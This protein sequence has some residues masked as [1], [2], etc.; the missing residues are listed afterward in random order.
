MLH[1]IDEKES[2]AIVG[3]G[4]QK[5]AN[6][7]DESQE[8]TGEIATEADEHGV[9]I[10]EETRRGAPTT[11]IVDYVEGE[12]IDLVVMDTRNRSGIRRFLAGS[13]TEKVL[14]RSEIPVLAVPR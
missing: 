11:E 4:W 8:I 9:A 5:K 3:Q 6:L 14:R 10:V 2:A 1:V 12:G 13:T 7:T